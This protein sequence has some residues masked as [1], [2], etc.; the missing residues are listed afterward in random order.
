MVK[1]KKCISIPTGALSS[2][3]HLQSYNVFGD[4]QGNSPLDKSQLFD[5]KSK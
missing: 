2:K 5:C 1:K 3:L 4:I